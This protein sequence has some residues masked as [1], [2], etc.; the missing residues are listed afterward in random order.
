M[1]GAQAIAIIRNLCG[2][3]SA[4][5][6]MTD[7]VLLP[8]VNL[9]NQ[10]IWSELVAE[11]PMKCISE[12]NVTYAAGAL[13]AAIGG[14]NQVMS[15]L[16]VGQTPQSGSISASNPVTPIWPEGY[17]TIEDFGGSTLWPFYEQS[18]M[19]DARW[20]LIESGTL[21]LRPIPQTAAY[22]YV[23]YI[24]SCPDMASSGTL[25]NSR[26]DEAHRIVCYR[27]AQLALMRAGR[28]IGTMA[29]MEERAMAKLLPSIRGNRQAPMEIRDV[30]GSD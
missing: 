14:S 30:Y 25:L 27:A 10:E 22:L 11:V 16:Y 8:L 21:I 28:E 6:P 24:A 18:R 4:L 5:G 17:S 23:K 3:T 26:L 29:N 7:A 15:V 9:A 2:E 19:T 12:Q 13:N 20:S 1:T